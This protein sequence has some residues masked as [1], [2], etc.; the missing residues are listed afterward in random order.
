MNPSTLLDLV[1]RYGLGTVG[2]ALLI[3]L[4]IRGEFVFRYP[5]RRR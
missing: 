1:S 4:L 3:Y 5:A 2:V